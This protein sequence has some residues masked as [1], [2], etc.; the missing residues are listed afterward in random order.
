MRLRRLSVEVGTDC[1]P[2]HRRRTA[3]LP[4]RHGVKRIP[5][6]FI[7][8]EVDRATRIVGGAARHLTDPAVGLTLSNIA[9]QRLALSLSLKG[10]KCQT[11][12]AENGPKQSETVRN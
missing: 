1:Q 3:F 4:P 11:E 2:D 10:E 7:G 12:T 5:R 6:A 9:D 8:L